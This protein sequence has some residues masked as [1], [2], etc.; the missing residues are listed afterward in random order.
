MKR[1]GQ[2]DPKSNKQ[3]ARH[4]KTE[5]LKRFTKL[6]R[7]S[8]SF[9][10]GSSLRTTDLSKVQKFN[11]QTIASKIQGPKDLLNQQFK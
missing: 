9:L 11:L 1:S 2:R 7:Q 4:N 5:Q 3:G 8:R 6:S 10:T